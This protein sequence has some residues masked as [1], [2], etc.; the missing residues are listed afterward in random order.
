MGNRAFLPV[1]L[2][3]SS[4]RFKARVTVLPCWASFVS[5]RVAACSGRMAYSALPVARSWMACWPSWAW[6]TSMSDLL[7]PFFF[8]R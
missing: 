5:A 3:H 6:T 7:S 4:W 1:A 8:S 2:A